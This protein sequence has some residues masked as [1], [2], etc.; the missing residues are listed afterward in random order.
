MTVDA[1]DK[2]TQSARL[3]KQATYV[4]MAVAVTL[5]AAQLIGWIVTDSVSLLSSLLD[6]LLDGL[7]SL[8]NVV[9]VH[10]AITPADREHRFGHGKAEPLGGLGQS[11][12][13]TGS[14][15]FLLFEA[16]HRLA[17]PAS[18]SHTAVGIGVMLF[19]MIVSLG[20][21]SYERTIVKRTHSLVIGADEL[22][23]RSH[24]F[25]GAGVAVSLAVTGAFGWPYLDPICG[26]A[27]GLWII[28][29][30]WGVARKSL[31]QLM[32]REL[33]DADRA[34]IRAL[35]LA[36]PLVTSVHDLR[37]RTS[38]PRTFI[39]IHLEMPGDITLAQAHRIADEVEA[40]ICAAF[41]NAEVITHE[42]PA[43]L[44]EPHR[45][46]SAQPAAARETVSIPH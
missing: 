5:I 35:A 43:G 4:S 14:A 23:Y 22:H 37:T 25:L 24:L 40:T 6:S 31:V 45:K 28:Y 46:F 12:F 29:A 36:H 42:D 26:M 1:I 39:Q 38:G 7:A 17:Q 15:L 21:V 27:I 16:A 18:V 2:A 10:H 11:A 8:L 19:V 9:A 41:P 30:A 20:L 44:A 3:M 33:P 13:I 34:Q 32:D